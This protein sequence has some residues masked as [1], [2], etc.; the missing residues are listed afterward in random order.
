[1]PCVSNA[2]VFDV[3]VSKAGAKP[4]VLMFDLDKDSKE[5]AQILESQC[6][7]LSSI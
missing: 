1:V 7:G 2:V 3:G 5:L 4:P 6:H